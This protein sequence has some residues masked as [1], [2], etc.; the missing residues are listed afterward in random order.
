MTKKQIEAMLMNILLEIDY[1]IYRGF[2]PEFS[3]EPEDIEPRLE[4]LVRI[5]EKHLKESCKP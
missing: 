5:V 4:N 1:D 2:L 3:E